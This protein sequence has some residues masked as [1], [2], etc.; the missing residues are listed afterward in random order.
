MIYPRDIMLKLDIKRQWVLMMTF[1]EALLLWTLKQLKSERTVYAVFHL[2]KGKKSSQSIQDAF[3]FQAESVFYTFPNLKRSTFDTFIQSLVNQS[4]LIVKEDHS[5]RITDLGE[6]QLKDYFTIHTFPA[7]LNGMKYQEHSF[8]FWNRLGILIQVLSNLVND[9]RKYYPITRDSKLLKWVK[10]FMI[11]RKMPKHQIT[12]ALYNELYTIFSENPPE[13]P[14]IIVYRLTGYQQIGKTIEQTARN[15]SLETTEYW[16]RFLNL[17][18]YVMDQVLE[19]ELNFPLLFSIIHDINK[20]FPMTKS[21]L[22][23]YQLLLNDYTIADISKMRNLKETTI[24]DHIIEIALNHPDFNIKPFIDSETEDKI[25]RIAK[26]T[27]KQKLKPIKEQL[28][29]VSYFQI[30]LALAR[31]R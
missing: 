19:K 12:A 28:N 11:T 24:Q 6:N 20:P 17:L 1:F 23:T 9:N 25:L 7:Y 26:K 30:R 31:N 4:L 29:S 3:L 13:S 18:H 16:Y 14:E 8:V 10:H 27:G 5:Y 22:E 15:L 2:L 21:T